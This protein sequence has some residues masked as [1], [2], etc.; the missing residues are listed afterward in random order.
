MCIPLSVETIAA[1]CFSKCTIL[2]TVT[3]DIHSH[4]S[5]IESG[6]FAQCLSL[7]S[8]SLPPSVEDLGEN[9]FAECQ[10][11]SVVTV[12]NNSKLSRVSRSAFSKC[13]Q[14]SSISIPPS[15][16]SVFEHYRSIL[17]VRHGEIREVVT[18]VAGR[19]ADGCENHDVAEEPE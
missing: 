14:L 1:F 4:V 7:E 15:L 5:R 17:E 2:S 11:L 13:P 3:F 18:D 10:H 16:Q 19:A 8:I 9:C 12:D 6:T